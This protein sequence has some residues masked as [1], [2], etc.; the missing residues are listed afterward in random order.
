MAS[1]A[2]FA[3]AGAFTDPQFQL[4]VRALN[5]RKDVDL[6]SS[7]SVTARD[8]EQATIDIIREFR[9]PTDFS[10]PQIP[11][12]LGGGQAGGGGNNAAAAAPQ[13]V[14]VTPSTPSAWDHKDVGVKLKVT[15]TIK[16]DNYAID[17]DLN[18]EVTEFEGFINYGSP[19]QTVAI[20]SAATTPLGSIAPT[21]QP[22]TLTENVINQPIFAIRRL[23]TIVT[24]LDGETIV[25]PRSYQPIV[26]F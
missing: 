8:Q 4:V 9:Y 7:P 23:Q 12:S 1:P 22:V 13:S 19:I 5:Q 26:N 10:P 15:P 6:L 20:A 18:P 16:G 14:P 3:L 21:P 11:T 17:L 24:L 25:M 2:A